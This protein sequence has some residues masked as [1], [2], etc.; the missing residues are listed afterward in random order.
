LGDDLIDVTDGVNN[1]T[2]RE[3]PDGDQCQADAGDT[4]TGCP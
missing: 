2:A 1:D 3:G 4:V